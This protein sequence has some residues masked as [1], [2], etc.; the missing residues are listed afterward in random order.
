VTKPNINMTIKE[1]ETNIGA[2]LSDVSSLQMRHRQALMKA[3]LSTT[4]EEHDAAM[5]L[6][7][8]LAAEQAIAST[9]L[10]GW[11]GALAEIV[12]RRDQMHVDAE[13]KVERKSVEACKALFVTAIE[14]A[15][16]VDRLMGELGAA[17]RDFERAQEEANNAASPAMRANELRDYAQHK[18]ACEPL[19][20]LRL[21]YEQVLRG[22]GP[23]DMS[24]APRTLEEQMRLAVSDLLPPETLKKAA[25]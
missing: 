7:N 3:Q 11:R 20:K 12:D 22:T 19:R 10:E 25:A 4:S 17:T 23:L 6:A 13:A 2:A 9:N 24:I 5:T 14:K 21:G 8:T 18:S 16:H 1:I 15:A